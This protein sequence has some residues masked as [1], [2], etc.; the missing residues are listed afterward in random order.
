[1]NLVPGDP[2]EVLLGEQA[3]SVDVAA[4][5]H[6]MWLDRPVPEQAWFFLRDFVTG[7]LRTSLPPFQDRVLPRLAQV[8]PRTALLATLAVLLALCLSLPLGVLSAIRVGTKV[9]RA[10]MAFAVLG[11]SAPSFLLGQLLILGV[12]IWLGWLPISG[13]DRLS[14]VILPAVTLGLGLTALLSR[15][16]R[17]SMLDVL[18]EEY[19][20][21]ARARGLPEWRVIWRHAFRNALLPILT[22]VGLQLGGALTGAVVIE[23][24][25]NWPGLGTLLLSSIDRR[26]YNSVR[27]CVLVFTLTYLAINLLTD[28]AYALAD[29]RGRAGQRAGTA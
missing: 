11:I 4:L 9:D 22:V 14:S 12:G 7:Q 16:V 20:L 29:P 27:A 13:D 5:R 18:R 23:K 10:A 25:F 21:A 15:M 19:V 2:V 17:A 26:D 3:Q 28:L 6:Q 1:L 24:V 8:A